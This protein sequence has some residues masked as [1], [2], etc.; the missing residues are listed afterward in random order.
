MSGVLDAA[1]AKV[2]EFTLDNPW[3]DPA[4]AAVI[5][6]KV[7]GLMVG[8]DA[9]WGG[10]EWTLDGPPE[11]TVHLPIV[12]VETGRTS[13]TFTQAGK[14]DGIAIGYGKHVLL[15]HKSC[16]SSEDIADPN[17]PYWRRLAIDSQVSTYM[18]QSIQE[19]RPLDGCLFDVIR[20]P[21]IRPKKLTKADVAEISAKGSYCGFQV[22]QEEY[23][24][25]LNGQGEET[26]YLYFVRLAAETLA[27]PEKYFQR[28]MI[29]R[30][31]SDVAEYAGELWAM[32]DEIRLAR[33]SGRHYR[34]S[35]ACL[36]WGRPCEFLGICSGH[37]APESDNWTRAEHVH[38]ELDGIA[39]GRDVLT[40]SRIKTFQTCRR[41][42]FYKYEMGIRRQNEDEAEALYLGTCLHEGLAQWWAEQKGETHGS[43]HV[44][45]PSATAVDGP[46]APSV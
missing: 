14:Y 33:V 6:A 44:A 21:G 42:H 11:V 30:L 1:L 31:D 37:D 8:Y 32:A 5:G 40:N 43:T 7:K 12:N 22:A 45:E 28:R 35:A 10:A 15:E 41:R 19:G 4:S 34:N 9:R 29:P 13:R 46:N 20:K 24:A 2:D 23:E 16:S 39:D 36:E 38:G 26:P 3:K 25:V 18:L 17:A 27:E